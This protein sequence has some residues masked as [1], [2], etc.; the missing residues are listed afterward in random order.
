[1]QFK[2]KQQPGIR[3]V[4]AKT[5]EFWPELILCQNTEDVVNMKRVVASARRRNPGLRPVLIEL[6]ALPGI[7]QP[8][9]ARM[10]RTAAEVPES[11]RFKV[12]L[13]E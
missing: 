11:W 1:M 8:G 3:R 2:M 7:T 13:P 5:L 12:E 4:P 10:F 6:C 9:E